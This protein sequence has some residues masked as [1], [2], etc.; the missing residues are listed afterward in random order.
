MSTQSFD[1]CWNGLHENRLPDDTWP[2][3]DII[4]QV[5]RHY[6]KV[7]DRGALRALD[8]G[9]GSGPVT[10]FLARAGF[11]VSAVDGSSVAVASCRGRLRREGLQAEVVQ[12]DLLELPWP[13]GVFDFAQET[14][15]LYCND[16][17]TT[18]R[19]VAEVHRVLKPGGIFFSRTPAEDCWGASLGRPEGKGAW[20]DAPDGPF[21]N[22]GLARFLYREDAPALYAPFT[23]TAV[24]K[25]ATT[26]DDGA[27][28]LSSYIVI[29]RK[30]S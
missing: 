30:D 16:A 23:V 1:P 13:D 5:A 14:H 18:S 15:C 6:F 28:T 11:A 21:A 25:T 29:C 19:I 27:H 8:L 2:T 12:G 4:R 10:W 26:L 22:M 24:E 17:A 7:P 9:C 20:R 3:D